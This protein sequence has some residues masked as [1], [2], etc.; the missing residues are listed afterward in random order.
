MGVPRVE[1]CA[2]EERGSE[3]RGG[4]RCSRCSRG[5]GGEGRCSRCSR[6]KGGEGGGEQE[7]GLQLWER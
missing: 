6:G 5:K 7:E 1:I 4:S 2:T 3:E